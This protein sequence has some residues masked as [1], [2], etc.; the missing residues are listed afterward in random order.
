MSARLPRQSGN[1]I[2]RSPPGS[3]ELDGIAGKWVLRHLIG[4]KKADYCPRS[5]VATQGEIRHLTM[6]RV[7]SLERVV[8]E[9]DLDAKGV[10]DLPPRLY[11]LSPAAELLALHP[12]LVPTLSLSLEKDPNALT[13]IEQD[14]N[15]TNENLDEFLAA[16]DWPPAVVGVAVV[17]E[18]LINEPSEDVRITAA[19]LRAGSRQSAIRMRRYDFDDSVLY[20]A[21]LVPQLSDALAAT[22]SD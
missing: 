13:A 21:D 7:N 3:R 15:P 10:W 1:S 9:L 20:G 6:C 17:L 2:R 4:H 8:V 11:A 14:Q 18:R 5:P 19:V 12:E 22:L 16:I